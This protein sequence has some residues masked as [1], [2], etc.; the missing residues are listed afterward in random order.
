MKGFYYAR[1]GTTCS[2]NLS[3]CLFKY[4]SY[5]CGLK[6]RPCFFDNVSFGKGLLQAMQLFFCKYPRAPIAPSNSSRPTSVGF[7][8]SPTTGQ[9]SCT[10]PADFNSKPLSLMPLHSIPEAFDALEEY[11]AACQRSGYEIAATVDAIGGIPIKTV[12]DV[13][14]SNHP[15]LL[16]KHLQR[17]SKNPFVSQ[18]RAVGQCAQATAAINSILRA[19]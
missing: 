2:P 16:E 18:L 7:A 10:Y 14:A 1:E 6:L 11:A 17:I 5:L 15:A 3:N 4:S 19:T 8:T 13:A 12:Y 9:G